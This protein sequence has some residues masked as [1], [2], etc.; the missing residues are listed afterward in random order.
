MSGIHTKGC[1]EDVQRCDTVE[2]AKKIKLL[3]MSRNLRSPLRSSST[4]LHKIM[5][6]CRSEQMK[7]MQT[8]IER[9]LCTRSIRLRRYPELERQARIHDPLRPIYH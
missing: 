2:S 1:K 7:P 3:V 4:Q 6:K 9:Y 8:L 5:Q